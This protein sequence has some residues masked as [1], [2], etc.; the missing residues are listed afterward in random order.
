[1]KEPLKPVITPD[2]TFKVIGLGGVGGPIARGLAVF[3][4]ASGQPVRLVLIDGD[5]FEPS[6]ASRM[7]FGA[8]GNKAEVVR[9]ELLPRFKDSTLELDAIEEFV[10]P[11]NIDRLI[12][13][14]D[15]VMLAVDNHATRKL[16][17]DHCSKLKNVCLISGGNDGVENGMRGTFG[18]V[19]VYLRRNG[20]DITFS[21]TAMHPEIA[22]PQDKN[23]A[24]KSCTDLIKSVPQIL[25]TNLTV[26]SAM[27][28]T[29]F[30]E[31]SGTRQYEELVFDIAEGLMR[32]IQLR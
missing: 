17:S 12:S 32:P 30:L 14:D 10:T 8:C 22:S 27:L 18:N 1:M 3:L 9:S 31:L 5:Q 6:N 2:S 19:Q 7:I 15:F 21:L 28:N 26:A 4:A 16:V 25:F 24:D 20:E 11:E 23:P 13:E 29:L